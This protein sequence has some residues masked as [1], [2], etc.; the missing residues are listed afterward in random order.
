MAAFK[1]NFQPYESPQIRGVD[2]VFETDPLRAADEYQEIIDG[3]KK[4]VKAA[5]K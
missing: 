2:P 1:H 4:A 5:G 3:W